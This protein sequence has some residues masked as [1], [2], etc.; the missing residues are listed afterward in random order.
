LGVTYSAFKVHSSHVPDALNVG[1][2]QVRVRV[3]VRV[4]AR[5]RARVG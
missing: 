5:V 3:R 2:P 4:R 1:L